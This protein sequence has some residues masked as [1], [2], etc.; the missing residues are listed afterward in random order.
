M[1]TGHKV[2]PTSF[3][4]DLWLG[5]DRMNLLYSIRTT[6]GCGS[7]APVPSAAAL[8]VDADQDGMISKAELGQFI[9]KN[10]QLW[11]M[12]SVNL[13]LPE[14]KCREIATE[15]AYQMAKKPL[16]MSLKD[17]SAEDKNREP[18]LDEFQRFL[19]FVKDP[20][21]QLEYFHRCVFTTYDLDNSGYLDN[22]ELDKFLDVFYEAGSIFAGDARLPDK[23]TL[24]KNI[25]EQFDED[26]DGKLEFQEL[27][28]L[29]SGGASTL[30]R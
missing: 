15:V 7:S 4:F 27:R 17:M 22:Q 2:S 6:M 23:A 26:G 9:E 30:P 3:F 24:K 1:Q 16:N 28:T 14:P 8:A 10:A 25:L 13:N 11:A 21:G 18:T 29:I 12:L 5:T 19:D 20:K